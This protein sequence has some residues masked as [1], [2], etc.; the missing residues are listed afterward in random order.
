MA[1]KSGKKSQGRGKKNGKSASSSAQ[2]PK[3]KSQPSSTGKTRVEDGVLQ[4]Q[5]PQHGWIRAVYH[6]DIRAELI[7]NGPQGRYAV[8]R[9]H[10]QDPD[11]ITSFHP[12]YQNT[13]PDRNHRHE[14]LFRYEQGD[15]HIP[16][17]APELWMHLGRIVL[18]LEDNPVL[19]WKELPWVL[20]SAYQGYEI[21]T[22]RRLNPSITYQ[23]IRARMPRFITIGGNQK[24]ILMNTLSMRAN[25]FR[26]KAC[27]L[28][29]D[30]REG[31]DRIKAYFDTLLSDQDRA[32]NSTKRFRDL[33]KIEVERARDANKGKYLKRAGKRA[34]D[35]TTRDERNQVEERR[36][37]KLLEEHIKT[38]G[39]EPRPAIDPTPQGRTQKRKRGE[40]PAEAE[41]EEEHNRPSKRKVPQTRSSRA[42]NLEEH[43]QAQGAAPR[44]A[45]EPTPQVR[46]QKRKR[47]ES[48]AEAEDEEENTRPPK[49]QQRADNG[50]PSSQQKELSRLPYSKFKEAVEQMFQPSG[51]QEVLD[52]QP[53]ND[54][55]DAD[56][57]VENLGD[58]SPGIHYSPPAFD[59]PDADQRVE[60]L[61]DDSPGIHY[62]PPASDNELGPIPRDNASHPTYNPTGPHRTLAEAYAAEYGNKGFGDKPGGLDQEA[63]QT[64]VEQLSD[65][66]SSM[67]IT[68]HDT[69]GNGGLVQ[70][71]DHHPG[72]LNQGA[73]QVDKV[74]DSPS[75]DESSS[76]GWSYH[77]SDFTSDDYLS[78]RPSSSEEEEDMRHVRP[79]DGLE[80]VMIQHMLNFARVDAHLHLRGVYKRFQTSE[81]ESYWTQYWQLYQGYI[82][83]WAR[84]GKPG[85][86]PPLRMLAKW[87][88]HL[89][90]WNWKGIH[91]EQQ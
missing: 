75:Q 38:F 60:N 81:E 48:P 51:R 71:T 79:R 7:E 41:D 46:T 49:R 36:K 77:A 24:E 22:V 21:E 32:S 70:K 74:R 85:K 23:D 78:Q 56:Q 63:D 37:E 34:L 67:G 19:F 13:G 47:G 44:P 40:N 31:S 65:S 62:S 11:D 20:S 1:G 73:D 55:L 43:V 90:N 89:A 4:Y 83:E 45:I 26:V 52:Q 27:C 39:A 72:G 8:P 58:D 59:N 86:P 5:D 9:A 2:Q 3:A 57:R 61:G 28:A 17:D 88:K 54:Q 42:R 76:S 80:R 66:P 30:D 35:D 33:T 68:D 25:R 91:W 15:Y 29:W 50:S 82:Y 53:Q 18:D 14:V 69:G 64:D 87:T 16:A 12:D 10:G 84:L 6:S